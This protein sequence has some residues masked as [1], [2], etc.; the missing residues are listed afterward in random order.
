LIFAAGEDVSALLP[1]HTA[2]HCAEKLRL[3]FKQVVNEGFPDRQATLSVGLAIGH[4]LDPLEDTLAAARDM[5]YAAKK[6]QKN[7]LAIQYRSRGG[8]PIQ[9]RSSW[10]SAPDA[11]LTKWITLLENDDLPSK[12][13]YDIRRTAEGYSAWPTDNE[14]AVALQRRALQLDLVRLLSRKSATARD[15]VRP[16]VD[17]LTSPDDAIDLANKIIIAG[18]IQRAQQQ[19]RRENA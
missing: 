12:V 10:E 9:F 16:F 8:A 7:A 5:E 4:F 14:D 19:A 11:E 6:G 2:V 17:R 18:V 1:L 15:E 3:H 13:A